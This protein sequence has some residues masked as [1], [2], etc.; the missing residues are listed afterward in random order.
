M[1]LLSVNVENLSLACTV[2]LFA[3]YVKEENGWHCTLFL[4]P[5]HY[6]TVF[7][8]KLSWCSLNCRL[9]FLCC[10]FL[11]LWVLP[12]C[13]IK[14]VLMK[15]KFLYF[16]PRRN[17]MRVVP[18]G[19]V[20]VLDTSRTCRRATVGCTGCWLW[21]TNRCTPCG[22]CWGFGHGV[23]VAVGPVGVPLTYALPMR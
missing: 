13:N 16:V 6:V 3:K 1:L 11:C 19:V 2:T 21:L 14:I 12:L 10:C 18:T 9:M 7:V 20:L 22:T 17:C 8:K 15:T 5:C 4:I 23:D